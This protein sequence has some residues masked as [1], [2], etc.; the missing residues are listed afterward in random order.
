MTR[1]AVMM[2]ACLVTTLIAAVCCVAS[3]AVA[4]DRPQRTTR[5]PN[6]ILILMDDMG[7]GDVGFTGNPFAETPHIDALARQGLVFG[8]AYAIAPNCAPTRAFLMSGQYTPRHGIYTVVDPRQPAGSPWHTLKA[9][10]SESD[11]ANDVVTIAESLQS[12]GYA[13]G[14]FGLWNLGRGRSGPV[15]PGGQGF[16]TVAFPETIQFGKDAYFDAAGNY[17]SDRLTDEVL[18]RAALRGGHP[19]ATGRLLAR[20]GQARHDGGSDGATWARAYAR[21]ARP[22]KWWNESAKASQ[23]ASIT[24]SLTPT[25]PQ[26]ASPS[27]L[28]IDTRTFAAVPSCALM[29]RTL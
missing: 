17:L 19:R 13:T 27:V 2:T 28:S 20:P 16:D 10:K 25:V 8:Q 15:T 6:V 9:A 24:F 18:A 22:R 4:A 26:T 7:W 12:G 23:L 3:M 11:L 14:F 29:T 1:V 5:P 21:A